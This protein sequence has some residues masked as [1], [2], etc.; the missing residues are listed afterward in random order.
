[1]DLADAKW[2]KELTKENV[3]LK[4]LLAEAM[5][6]SRVLKEVTAKMVSPSQKEQAVEHV[7]AQRLCSVRRACRY[8]GLPR[9]T[10]RYIPQPLTDRQQQLHRVSSLRLYRDC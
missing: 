2:L 9:S 7:V 5:L 4:Q 1:M 10:Y 6:E 8:L 3:E